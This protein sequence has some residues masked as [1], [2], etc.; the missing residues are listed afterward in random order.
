MDTLSSSHDDWFRDQAASR[1]GMDGARQLQS[2]SFVRGVS[3]S[4]VLQMLHLERK[5]CV[6]EVVSDC[7]FGTLT[8]VNG[9]LVD[10][11][12]DELEGEEAVYR[13][14]TWPHPQTT[15]LDGVNLFRHTVGLPI[16]RLLM[17]LVRRQDEIERPE[18]TDSSVGGFGREPLP[19]IAERFDNWDRLVETLVINGALA[20][21][22]L[23]ADD[24][25]LLALADEFGG[26][27][28]GL[29]ATALSE[30]IP[31]TAGLRDWLLLAG[32]EADDLVVC[33]NGLQLVIH[34]LNRAHDLYAYALVESTEALDRIR[35][36]CR[37][38]SLG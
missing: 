12:A 13:I 29:S 33:L 6:L 1:A 16:S 37:Q 11:G 22:V 9:E 21:A 31:T 35:G 19:S 14:L 34:P 7:R 27:V 20:A 36:A 5:T 10:A 18:R 28:D 3:L 4:G 15:I 24:G 17:E 26:T 8:L 32:G 38:A 23:A 25:R 2:A 30:L